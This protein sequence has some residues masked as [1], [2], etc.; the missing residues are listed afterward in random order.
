MKNLIIG[1]LLLPILMLGQT[2]ENPELKK[3][4]AVI[5]EKI[6]KKESIEN[7]SDE[8][9]TSSEENKTTEKK[10]STEQPEEKKLKDIVVEKKI[11]DIKEKV[12][13]LDDYKKIYE[14]YKEHVND[15]NDEIIDKVSSEYKNRQTFIAD[16]Y[17]KKIEELSEDET[18]KRTNSIAMMERFIKKYPKDKQFTPDILFRLADLYFEKEELDF[19]Q[20]T[21]DYETQMAL[22]DAKKTSVQPVE[23]KKTFAKTL[24]YFKRIINDFPEYNQ[25]D[26]A[27]YL[28]GYIY[29]Q[30]E[31][32][33]EDEK[34]RAE[35]ADEAKYHHQLIVDKFKDSPYVSRAYLRIAEYYYE[36]KPDADKSPTYYKQFAIENYHNAINV[37]ES[38]VV[39]YAM[40]KLAWSHY[41]I[42]DQN[43]LE[44]YDKAIDIFASLVQKYDN[45]KEDLIK[46]YRE[47]SIDFTSI[48]FVEGYENDLNKLRAYVQKIGNAP[49]GREVLN[50]IAMA[51]Y[52]GQ[53]WKTS[54]DIYNMILEYYPLYEENPLLYDYIISAY[55]KLGN[56][57]GTIDARERFL[58]DYSEESPW[59]KE[60]FE[61]E[62]AMAI[63]NNLNS[64][65]LYDA[66]VYHHDQA[67]KFLESG[68]KEDSLA[69]FGMASKLYSKFLEDYPLS[70][71]FYNVQFYYALTLFELSQFTEAAKMF[72]KVRDNNEYFEHA[73]DASRRLIISYQNALKQLIAEGSQKLI[74][75]PNP[76]DLEK[77]EKIE[78]IEMNEIYKELVAVR[79]KFVTMFPNNVDA[80]VFAFYNASDFYNHLLFDEA[81]KRFFDLIAKY[82]KSEPARYALEDIYKS[83]M[84]ERKYDDAEKFYE[85]VQ[86]DQNFSSMIT[87]K[88][89]L[90]DIK[91][92]QTLSVY[93]KAQ[94]F[95]N[96]KKYEE[97]AQ[98]YLRLYKYY[99]TSEYALDALRNA[100]FSYKE[101]KRPLKRIDILNQII[102]HIENDSVLKNDKKSQ[103]EIAAN[104]LE[105]ADISERF[106]DFNMTISY[107]E[108]YLTKFSSGGDVKY[109]YSKLPQLYFNNQNY[110]KAAQLYST[111]GPKLDEKNQVLYLFYAINSYEKAQNWEKVIEGYDKFIRQFSNK[112]QYKEKQ[113]EIIYLISETY[114][115]MGQKKLSEEY[116]KKT[117]ET[118]KKLKASTTPDYTRAKY[119]AAKTQFIEIERLLPA[120]EK[121]FIGGKN[122]GVAIKLKIDNAKF[123]ATL[124]DQVI[125]TYKVPEWAIA[126]FFRK[127]YLNKQFA[128]TLFAVKPPENLDDDEKDAY[129]EEIETFA[130]PFEEAALKIYTEAYEYSKKLAIEN[131]WTD[132]IL[133]ELNKMDKDTYQIPKRL[134]DEQQDELIFN[135]VTDKY[136]TEENIKKEETDVKTEN[137]DEKKDEIKIDEIKIDDKDVDEGEK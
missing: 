94:L 115:K 62:K 72:K 49:Y 5:E 102:N 106:F 70:P 27:Y 120:Y 65:H 56:E 6:E 24:N 34:K 68:K 14:I 46:L 129:T 78:P 122:P 98:E 11:K 28:T 45:D 80:P 23:P 59:Y 73:E 66:A 64:K 48:S 132:K 86:K 135:P 51:Y 2:Q 4:N 85:L 37:K 113:V 39:D 116:Q 107:F 90:T 125:S 87:K 3:E 19:Q 58:K 109:V 67:N 57:K 137:K 111:Y 76:D 121:I 26:G 88:E 118:F 136:I 119:L 104:I 43:H 13:E 1:L 54:I 50:K 15:Y 71:D 63:L 40:Y 41:T 97:S 83:Y 127:G 99:P 77:L 89:D 42:A 91:K 55:V 33:E 96:E 38:D 61:N 53:I 100:N 36:K 52:D 22:F 74:E 12:I 128:E 105:I 29:L 92:F 9:K 114:A 18:S 44:D 35:Y 84:A 110:E 134:I 17:D 108:K 117:Y 126:S 95:Y 20:A 131:E 133:A 103:L 82:P 69:S 21:K 60:N 93:K 79:D 47:E 7:K 75:K 10:N 31:D 101:A 112:P 8:E 30:L 16:L 32:N 123:L 25:L 81:R 124:Y 130:E